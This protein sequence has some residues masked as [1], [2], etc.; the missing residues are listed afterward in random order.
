MLPNLSRLRIRS[1]AAACLRVRTP[2]CTGGGYYEDQ[3]L[4]AMMKYTQ[5][6]HKL[7]LAWLQET[8]EAVK[9]GRRPE[10][11]LF[12]QAYAEVFF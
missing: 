9:R 4:E 10:R 3:H 7:D 11:A 2:A 5:L 1:A 8:F 12:N 6:K